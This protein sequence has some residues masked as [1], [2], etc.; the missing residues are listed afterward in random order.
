MIENTYS[1][2][3]QARN[4]MNFA[5][6]VSFVVGIFMLI[7]KTYAYYITSSA[8]ILS[9]AAESVIHV[10]AVG[11]AAYSMWLSFKPADEDHLY[12]HDKISFFSAGFEGA[13]IVIAAIFIAYESIKKILFGF[14]IDNINE[15]TLFIALAASINA[16]LSFY[17]IQKGKKYK[18][19]VLEANGKHI[20][21]DCWT[22]LGAIIALALVQLTGITFF[23][24]GIAIFIAL[25]ILWT[26]GK[27]IKKCI[28]G[29]MDQVDPELNKLIIASVEEETQKKQLE[30]HNLKHRVSGNKIFIE[31]HLLFPKE[32]SL[33]EAHEEAS[34][35]EANVKKQL[36]RSAEIV[37]HLEPKRDHDQ[38]HKKYGLQI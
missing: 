19:L 30:F 13:M 10:F 29:L 5:M 38:I 32:I 27:L 20:L 35:V 9:D 37:T 25:N 33:K 17:L 18:S 11:F 15:G 28:G 1:L 12:G 2:T 21:T 22:S 4:E 24:P 26:G 31:F 16:F 36:D 34:E 3:K 7:I 8:A 14:S 23:D 6:R